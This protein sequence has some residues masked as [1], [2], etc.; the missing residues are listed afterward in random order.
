MPEISAN[1]ERKSQVADDRTSAPLR[2]LFDPELAA[3][4]VMMPAIDIADVPEARRIE[5]E[6]AREMRA[7]RPSVGDDVVDVDDLSCPRAD[8]SALALRRY[9]PAKPRQRRVS[10]PALLFIHGGSFVTG[11]LH[12]EDDRCEAYAAGVGCAVFALDYRLAPE[13]PFPA[14]LD[15]CWLA[16][17]WIAQHAADLGVDPRRLAVGGL[18]AGG[19]LAAGLAQRA[20]DVGGPPLML[21]LLLF[22]VLD[23]AA[24]NTSSRLFT[25]T[26]VLDSRT[27]EVMWSLY[28]GARWRHGGHPPQYASPAHASDLR[29][30][31][32]AHICAAEFD[33]LRDE[34]VTY[35]QRLLE[36]EVSV[37]LRLYARAFHSFDSFAAA[38]LGSTAR[39]DQMD[40][41]K[42]AFS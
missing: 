13:H 42:A 18:S 31:P 5:K 33:P 19:A 24:D 11:G 10:R 34:A 39:R 7:A 14:A 22:P 37:N 23:A 20:R 27:V 41:L 21:Q 12:S 6:L 28:L 17:T 16:L 2:R 8:G 38:R 29:D 25:D 9:V 30:L 1:R 40:A 32:A 3:M 15:D 26:P 36:H 35:A 4:Q